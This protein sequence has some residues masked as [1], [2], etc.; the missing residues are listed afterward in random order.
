V[1]G[2]QSRSFDCEVGA[3]FHHGRVSRSPPISRVEGR[4]GVPKNPFPA[5]A[6]SDVAC[7]FPALRLP[8]CFVS[9]IMWPI[10]PGRL[11]TM[12]SKPLPTPPLPAAVLRLPK[13]R[14]ICSA[15]A[16]TYMSLRR[17]CKLL[18]DLSSALAS[19]VVGTVTNS[20]D[21]SL[22][23]HYNRFP[24]T[25]IPAVTLSTSADFPVSPVIRLP[26]SVD[27]ATGRGGLLQFL[28]MSLSSCC[29]FN[30]VSVNRR[31]SQSATIHA[32]FALREGARP[33]RLGLSRPNP[34]L[35]S[36]RP[37]DSQPSQGWLC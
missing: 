10:M 11:S 21:P 34:R 36:L 9:R 23:D 31:I 35:L 22:H 28:G 1:G 29:R 30:P 14:K 26:C 3:Q 33:L 24:A 7:G 12:A 15:F 19:R 4:R 13:K 37:D 32:A 8:V 2:Y 27:F 16:L 25:T 20:R 18:S 17:S 6:T 5:P